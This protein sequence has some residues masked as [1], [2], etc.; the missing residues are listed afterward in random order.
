MQ[1]T[2]YTAHCKG[3]KNNAVY[4]NKCIIR[5][6]EDLCAVAAFDHVCAEY[7][8]SHRSVDNFMSA[9]CTVMD[10]DNDFSDNPEDWI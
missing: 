8:N 10:N 3:K 4:P 7:R 9:D 2:L 1:L 5:N 6:P